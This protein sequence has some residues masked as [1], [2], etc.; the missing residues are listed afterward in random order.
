MSPQIEFLLYAFTSYIALVNPLSTVPV[1]MTMTAGL[2][3]SA[4]R[5]TIFKATLTATAT[6]FFFALFGEVLFKIF[7]ISVN[8][9]KIVGGIIFFMMGNDMLNARVIRM[10]TL[11][12]DET[13]SYVNDISITP[14]AIPMICGPGAI[15]NSLILMNE[16]ETWDLRGIL[17]GV[18]LLINLIMMA[19]L[20]AGSQIS[21]FMGENGTKVM[22]K[23][24]GLIM[25]VIAVESFFAG[26]KPILRDILMI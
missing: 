6:M 8:A 12:D 10:K 15:T 5:R 16:A 24:M 19:G 17:F 9:F 3:S 13:H 1:F 14:L 20:M 18:I 26:L 4:R 21:K 22:L 2:N 25:M 7:S 23:L 11:S